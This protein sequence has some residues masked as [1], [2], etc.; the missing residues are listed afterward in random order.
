MKFEIIMYEEKYN[1]NIDSQRF[2]SLSTPKTEP[3]EFELDSLS[4][5][6]RIVFYL[7]AKNLLEKDQVIAT[8]VLDLVDEKAKLR[9]GGYKLLMWFNN[10]V[11]PKDQFHSY[12]MEYV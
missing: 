8:S 9:K 4:Y 2:G 12:G 3:V 1:L 5:D 10:Q 6:C 11:N 7:L